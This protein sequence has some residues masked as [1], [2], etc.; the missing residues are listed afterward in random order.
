MSRGYLYG[1]LLWGVGFLIWEHRAL[2]RKAHGD[3]LSEQVWW[4]LSRSW[5]VDVFGIFWGWLT[6]HFWLGGITRRINEA[7]LRAEEG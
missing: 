2:K 6:A 1:W 4:L 3:T 7:L 5:G